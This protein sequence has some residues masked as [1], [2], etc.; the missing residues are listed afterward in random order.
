MVKTRLAKALTV[1]F[2]TLGFAAAPASFAASYNP[3]V[4]SG[5]NTPSWN[6]SHSPN[7]QYRQSTVVD[8]VI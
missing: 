8:Q 4:S 7:S 6:Q 2:V 5:S 1:A 3:S